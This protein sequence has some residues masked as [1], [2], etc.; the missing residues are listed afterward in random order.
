MSETFKPYPDSGT[1]MAVGVKKGA[2]SPDYWGRITVNLNDLKNITTQDGL[3]TI[4]LSGWKK[5]D[6]SGKA[7]LS[8]AVDRFVPENAQPKPKS[9]GFDDL[10]DDIPY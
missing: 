9:S 2:K 5:M 7:Y 4:K 10:D 8:L 6:R 1:L 3:T